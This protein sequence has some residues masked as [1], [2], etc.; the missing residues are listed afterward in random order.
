MSVERFVGKVVEFKIGE[1]TYRMKCP[2]S[3]KLPKLLYLQERGLKN[4]AEEDYSKVVD[5]LEDCVRRTYTDWSEEGRS[6][7]V[8][9]H[10]DILLSKLP[11]TLGVSGE[12][13]TKR[14]EDAKN[15]KQK[16]V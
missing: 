9:Q 1:I 8:V 4:L 11:L 7:F 14:L 3:K 5:I 13:V 6:D 15:T 16:K 12:E 10:F 2:S